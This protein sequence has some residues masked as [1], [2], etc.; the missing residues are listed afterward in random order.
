MKI[1]ILFSTILLASCNQQQGIDCRA[2]AQFAAGSSVFKENEKLK[3]SPHERKLGLAIQNRMGGS[4]DRFAQ[5]WI[6]CR[7]MKAG[8]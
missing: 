2:V 4:S 5:A 1:L 6:I 3:V 8:T 7:K